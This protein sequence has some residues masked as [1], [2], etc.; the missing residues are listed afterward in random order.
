MHNNDVWADG[1]LVFYEVFKYLENHVSYDVLP[2]GLRRTEAFE[3]DLSFYLGPKWQT[4]YQPRKEVCQYLKHLQQITNKEPILLVAYVYHLY[5]GLLSGGQ[6]LQKKRNI[7]R[8]LVSTNA[9]VKGSAVTTFEKGISL[10]SLKDNLRS[11][12]DHMGMGLN[13]STKEQ[14]LKES[15][16]VFELNNEI[17]K[18]VKGVDKVNLKL[19]AYLL[20]FVLTSLLFY[21]M[22]QV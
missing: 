12:V 13:E 21:I 16:K 22:W 8:K 7:A 14:L 15:R 18:T 4:N 10:S 6:I 5:M 19:I 17:V 9:N 11:I 3:E 1:L 20:I 2:K